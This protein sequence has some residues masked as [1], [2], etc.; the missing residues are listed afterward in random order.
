MQ[1]HKNTTLRSG[2]APFKAPSASNVKSV[3]NNAKPAAAVKEPSTKVDGKKWYVEYYKNRADDNPVLIDQAE[4][5]NVIYIFKCVNTKVVVKG[6]VNSI[7]LDACEKSAI[8]FDSV[9]AS[10]EFINCQSC[11]L[12][13]SGKV[14]TISIDKSDGCDMYLSNDSKAVEIISSKSTAMNVVLV[15]ANGDVKELPIPEQF[16]TTLGPKGL[17]T[18]CVESLG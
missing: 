6:K 10:V 4:M 1:T 15:D 3:S 8:V 14:P 13:V 5:N 18:I 17:N 16:K 2:P 7:V 9:V 11:G 12:Q